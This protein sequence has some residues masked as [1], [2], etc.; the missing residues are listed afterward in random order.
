MGPGVRWGPQ[1]GP[2]G[3]QGRSLKSSCVFQ[4]KNNIFNANLYRHKIVNIGLGRFSTLGGSKNCERSEQTERLREEFKGVQG[5]GSLAGVARGSAV[6]SSNVVTQPKGT[7]NPVIQRDLRWRLEINDED[8][9]E[10]IKLQILSTRII[11]L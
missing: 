5:A 8:R 7:G 3:I 10:F 9:S 11:Y 4:H 2:V 1:W 6:V